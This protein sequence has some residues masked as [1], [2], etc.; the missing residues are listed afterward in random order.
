MATA[1]LTGVSARL[2]RFAKPVTFV[3]GQGDRVFTPSLGRRLAE[4]F[5]NGTLVEVPGSKTFVSLDNPKAV[6]EAIAA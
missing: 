3:W 2:T 1:D 6:I 4:V 5:S